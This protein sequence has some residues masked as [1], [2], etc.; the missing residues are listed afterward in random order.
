MP[1]I[2]SPAYMPM[3]TSMPYDQRA[4]LTGTSEGALKAS[5]HHAHK[6]VLELLGRE[7]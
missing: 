4:Q 6:K 7:E 2:C 1:S 5:Y 3:S